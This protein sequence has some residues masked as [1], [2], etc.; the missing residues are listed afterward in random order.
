MKIAL[1]FK[2]ISL[3]IAC[4]LSE[5]SHAADDV[6]ESFQKKTK[7]DGAFVELPTANTPTLANLNE[8]ATDR[9]VAQ[10]SASKKHKSETTE[11]PSEQND[12]VSQVNKQPGVLKIIFSHIDFPYFHNISDVCRFWRR[13]AE[14]HFILPRDPAEMH[15][16]MVKGISRKGFTRELLYMAGRDKS[17]FIKLHNYWRSYFKLPL[18][19]R[20]FR[21]VRN[22]DESI[23]IS[24][25]ERYAQVSSGLVETRDVLTRHPGI[26]GP[27]GLAMAVCKIFGVHNHDMGKIT[28]LHPQ[29]TTPKQ[30]E[31]EILFPYFT[32]KVPENKTEPC[33]MWDQQPYT[34]FMQDFKE[35]VLCIASAA[36][37]Q[38][39][40]NTIVMHADTKQL[41]VQ[42][43]TTALKS[44][45][46]EKEL[47]N[48]VPS[49]TMID[50]LRKVSK[51]CTFTAEAKFICINKAFEMCDARK[52]TVEDFICAA[53]LGFECCD[54]N[55]TPRRKTRYYTQTLSHHERVIEIMSKGGLQKEPES[56]LGE[57][58]YWTG[59]LASKEGDYPTALKH[60]EKAFQLREE[61]SG[62][63]DVY[64]EAAYA[65]LKLGK[66]EMDPKKKTD[67]FVEALRYIEQG[68]SELW[69][70]GV[71]DSGFG[72]LL[73]F[74]QTA[75]SA[76]F[77]AGDTFT[78]QT[79]KAVYFA[80]AL[81]YWNKAAVL[82]DKD[83]DWVHNLTKE[84]L[85]SIRKAKKSA[86]GAA[87][88][89]TDL[90]QKTF[91]EA[92]ARQY[93]SRLKQ[94]EGNNQ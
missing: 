88:Y 94:Q 38:D 42:R 67:Y 5:F 40:Q 53:D 13:A 24:M 55:F 77:K 36:L 26:W 8:D 46:E 1:S 7:V 34:V 50:I 31:K 62:G 59:R 52:L 19:Q 51:E 93:E 9:G 16:F 71:Y 64:E 35:S 33:W 49:E 44:I 56:T 81:E 83:P 89:T 78:D 2:L 70:D 14:G 25:N 75:G 82:L 47:S 73:L 12:F 21:A 87:K 58:H 39:E 91:F 18:E 68:L 60:F 48:L 86:E 6:G 28:S 76:A 41:L 74:Y 4:N 45:E 29:G 65:A 54:L 32:L 85:S 10:E 43:I 17:G 30:R 69:T 79:Q 15:N 3:L 72:T 66:S 23:T 37:R 63:E 20:L 27:Y 61:L 92:K 22:G 57:L 80:K 84:K 90:G 11:V